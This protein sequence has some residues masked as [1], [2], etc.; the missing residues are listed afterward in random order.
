MGIGLE[1]YKC[2]ELDTENYGS[3]DTLMN[4][5]IIS[6]WVLRLIRG[7]NNLGVKCM[8]LQL[9]RKIIERVGKPKRNKCQ[10]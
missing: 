7:V 3:V 9:I 5:A 8:C 2:G 10:Y 6:D 4:G 1:G